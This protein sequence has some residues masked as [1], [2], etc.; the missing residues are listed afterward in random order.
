MHLRYRCS[1][2]YM[3]AMIFV[4]ALHV[5]LV[6]G[7][8][9]PEAKVY[10]LDAENK[11]VQAVSLPS[12]KVSESIKL[13]Q[14]PSMLLLNP[15]GSRLLVFEYSNKDRSGEWRATGSLISRFKKPNSLSIFNTQD[16]KLI[17]R[18]EDVGWNAI[19]HPYFLWPQ[20]E[21]SAAW[22]ASG[23]FLTIL[24]WGYNKKN[25]EIVQLDI[26]NA[27]IAGRRLLSCRPGEVNPLLQISNNMAAVLY[28][29]RA[30][31]NNTNATHTLVLVN[32]TNLADS[33]EVSLPG[34][35]RNLASSPDGNYVYVL[36]DDG[37]RIK[38]PGK[39]HLHVVST[40]Q[41]AHLSSIDGGFSLD[42]A[43]T[44]Y[45]GGR[46]LISRLGKTGISTV[47]AFQQDQKKAEIEIPDVI[48]QMCMA[49]KT[50]RLYVLCYN[51]VQVI[52]LET[53]KL[54]GIIPTPHR[55]RGVW[56][57]GS[58]ERPPSSLAFD[59]TESI[60]ILGYEGDDES[61]VLDLKNL[62]VKG[63]IDLIS[64]LKAFGGRMLVAAAMGA[65][66][67]VG[68]AATGAPVMVYVP[69]TPSPQ[70]SSAIVDPSNQ[71]VYIMRLAR[72][73]V[74][75]LTTFKKVASITIPFTANYGFV[76]PPVPGRKPLLFVVGSHI[77]F[78]SKGS[79]RMEV[80]DMTT[81][82]KFPDQNW[83]GHCLYTSD[84]KYAVNYDSENIYLLDGTTLSNVMTIKGFKELRQILLATQGEPAVAV[85]Q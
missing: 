61:S 2:F 30:F 67:G 45:S 34:I 50:R 59:S 19:A 1:L 44:D 47:F 56:D 23:R 25:V 78:T 29:K 82:E 62:K 12:G 57:S 14:T 83:L 41:G 81:K 79:Y 11:A 24:A 53:L 58:R 69:N 80:I 77:G 76:P 20:A 21:I 7:Q 38:D 51:S 64:G 70:Y 18:L 54:V 27:R 4:L 13:E 46:T 5:P 43:V 71:F 8:S 63:T 75:D 73:Y 42:G 68:S 37:M 32:L 74:A 35:P 26:A 3:I 66:G 31:K 72:V 33:K 49:P 85:K 6:W 65:I 36:A 10:T 9:V 16:M 39:S 60:G 28:G 84:G 17:A 22:D 40:A 52:D 15:D 48:M 55:N